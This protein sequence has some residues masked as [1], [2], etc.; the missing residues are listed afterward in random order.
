MTETNNRTKVTAA[1]QGW[2][3]G[4]SYSSEL[5][6]DDLQ[7]DIAGNSLA[8]KQYTS[9]QQF[10]D[11]VLRPFGARFSERSRPTAIRGIYADGDTVIVLWDGE[12]TAQDKQPYTNTY[13]WFLTMRDGLVVRAVAFFDSIAFNDLWTRVQPAE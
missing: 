3:D 8:A 11:E 9:K 7:W 10:L 13:A 6:A 5:L 2:I 1:F 4:T 12:G